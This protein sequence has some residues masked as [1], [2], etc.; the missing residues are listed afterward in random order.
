[1][2]EMLHRLSEKFGETFSI[3]RDTEERNGFIIRDIIGNEYK[4]KMSGEF[5]DENTIFGFDL[6]TEMRDIVYFEFLAEIIKDSVN[7]TV[8]AVNARMG[9][10]L[11]LKVRADIVGEVIHE[12]LISKSLKREASNDKVSEEGGDMD[13]NSGRNRDDSGSNNFKTDGEFQGN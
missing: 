12:K 11:D 13:G 9:Y 1:M 10:L 7:R 2:G 4:F 5:A 8:E 3:T 6:A